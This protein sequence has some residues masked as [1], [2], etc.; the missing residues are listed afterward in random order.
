MM[1]GEKVA[2]ALP[3]TICGL[4]EEGGKDDGGGKVYLRPVLRIFSSDI[5]EVVQKI[6]AEKRILTFPLS[7]SMLL[8]F[9]SFETAPDRSKDEMHLLFRR[10]VIIFTTAEN[11]L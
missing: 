5:C 6:A 2:D 11:I 4:C 1:R 8:V 3:F 10:G 9:S 7:R